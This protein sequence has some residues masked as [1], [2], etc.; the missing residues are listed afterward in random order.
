MADAVKYHGPLRSR[1]LLPVAANPQP[2]GEATTMAR[3]RRR[4]WC[5][6]YERCLNWAIVHSWEGFHCAD[7]PV[8]DEDA[9]EIDAYVRHPVDG[10]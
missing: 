10:W 1:A 5:R 2:C 9:P 4:I 8:V 7:C 3:V 6:S